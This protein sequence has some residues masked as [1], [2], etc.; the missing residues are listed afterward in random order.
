LDD[1]DD[2][3]L[4]IIKH[5]ISDAALKQPSEWLTSAEAAAYLRVH[6]ET[7]VK[8]RAC[9]K[10]PPFHRIGPRSIRYRR[11]D[12]DAYVTANSQEVTQCLL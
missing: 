10:G 4:A 12:L 3:V 8:W 9:N 5:A 6:P 7:L 11:A 1:I 2:D